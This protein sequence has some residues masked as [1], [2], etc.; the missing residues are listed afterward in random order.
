MVDDRDWPIGHTG[1]GVSHIDRSARFYEA[2][3]RSPGM[4]MV[5]RI[6]RR[7]EPEEHE[8][9]DSQQVAWHTAPTT[10]IPD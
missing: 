6:T 7:F 8:S 1:T 2:A 3:L 9:T 4:K 5:V 10:R